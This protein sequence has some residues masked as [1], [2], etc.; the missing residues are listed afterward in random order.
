MTGLAGRL[1]DLTG[2]DDARITAMGAYLRLLGDWEP[3]TLKA[4]TLLVR[5]A[6]AVP[7]WPSG[8]RD[9][10]PGTTGAGASRPRWDHPTVTLDAPGDHFGVLEEHAPST[11]RLVERWLAAEL[12]SFATPGER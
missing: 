12:P 10:G 4:P 2:T 6:D 9:A 3:A 1:G 5:A 11:A 7:G 8:P